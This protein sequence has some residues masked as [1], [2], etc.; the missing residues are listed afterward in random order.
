MPGG[1]DMLKFIRLSHPGSDS[2]NRSDCRG[3]AGFFSNSPPSPAYLLYLSIE[4]VT[5]LSWVI[6]TSHFA[7]YRPRGSPELNHDVS[8]PLEASWW[9]RKCQHLEQR[10]SAF[11]PP[12]KNPTTWTALNGEVKTKAM[13]PN[14]LTLLALI[15][16]A[17][18]QTFSNFTAASPTSGGVFSTISGEGITQSEYSLR[19]AEGESVFVCCDKRLTEATQRTSPR[20]QLVRLVLLPL[21]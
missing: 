8:C 19:K 7:S 5:R 6:I 12:I 15:G 4:L 17:T 21:R 9:V 18:A 14:H 1:R 3:I 20:R 2:N 11:H 16:G 10:M 13:R